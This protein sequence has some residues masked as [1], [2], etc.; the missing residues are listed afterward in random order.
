MEGNVRQKEADAN[1]LIRR[2][3]NE[4]KEDANE[5]HKEPDSQVALVRVLYDTQTSP[6]EP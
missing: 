6:F 2:G 5:A 1:E 4:R 3:T